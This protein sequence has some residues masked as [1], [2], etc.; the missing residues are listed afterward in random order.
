MD[1]VLELL[2]VGGTFVNAQPIFIVLLPIYG[3]NFGCNFACS[4]LVFDSCFRDMCSGD[5]TSYMKQFVNTS[6]HKSHKP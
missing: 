3:L 6:V 2:I 5:Q 1:F 4:V